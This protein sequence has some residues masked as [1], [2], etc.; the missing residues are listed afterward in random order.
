MGTPLINSSEKGSITVL[1]GFLTP[2]MILMVILVVNI[3]QLVFDKIRLQYVADACAISAATVQ[4]AMLN[5]IA[6]LNNELVLEYGNLIATLHQW[7][8]RW[9]EFDSGYRVIQ[10]Y[11]RRFA[12]IR[13]LQNQSYIKFNDQALKTA[14]YVMRD[15]EDL[16][17]NSWRIA[18]YVTPPALNYEVIS[19]G[20]D[21]N[22]YVGEC[23][24]CYPKICLYSPGAVT[25]RKKLFWLNF[26]TSVPVEIRKVGTSTDFSL[27]LMQIPAQYSAGGNIF[28]Y[29][30]VLQAYA[31]AKPA[32]GHIYDR[33]PNYRPVLIR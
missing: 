28:G 15:N 25:L 29:L 4:S 23:Y 2:I 27:S 1:I 3:G 14:E 20:V 18:C 9:C 24:K 7:P 32:G 22:Y 16:T 13:G 26:S 30:P 12:Y 31:A 33:R 10:D 8:D 19:R 11:Q 17:S 21:F 5:E 6:D